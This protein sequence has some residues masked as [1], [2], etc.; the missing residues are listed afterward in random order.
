MFQTNK[1]S[2]KPWNMAF[3]GRDQHV[4]KHST[5]CRCVTMTSEASCC[6]RF[7]SPWPMR[8]AAPRGWRET[9][10]WSTCGWTCR[11]ESNSSGEIWLDLKPKKFSSGQIDY[12][13]VARYLIFSGM[14]LAN[15]SHFT[16]VKIKPE[17][18]KPV[19]ILKHGCSSPPNSGTSR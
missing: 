16:L 2:Y 6:A 12:V 8:A 15:C 11:K 10:W 7:W 3:F 13:G 5:C 4:P 1:L 9:N 19:K 14:C 18:V 17:E